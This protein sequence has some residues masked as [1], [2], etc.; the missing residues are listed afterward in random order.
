MYFKKL[1]LILIFFVINIAIYSQTRNF[2]EQ[3]Y[4]F[5]DLLEAVNNADKD[6][7]INVLNANPELVLKTSETGL[8][9][10]DYLNEAGSLYE[11]KEDLFDN[12]LSILDKYKDQAEKERKSEQKICCVCDLF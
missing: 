1:F 6:E 11:S 8:T 5:K 9:I 4:T 7:V 12:I 10:F 3:E 2:V